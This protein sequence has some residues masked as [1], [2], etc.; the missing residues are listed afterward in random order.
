M[1]TI[2]PTLKIKD[3]HQQNGIYELRIGRL[4]LRKGETED[5][6]YMQFEDAF[7]K[8][9][10]I[11]RVRFLTSK[12]NFSDGEMNIPKP[13][14]TNSKGE[15]TESGDDVLY[16]YLNGT[17]EQIV[18]MGSLGNMQTEHNDMLIGGNY[19][20]N[21][22]T[23]TK[24]LKNKTRYL[25]QTITE[26]GDIFLDL[27]GFE[28][29]TGNIVIK[30]RGGDKGGFV[31]VETDGRI[32]LNQVDK[33]NKLQAQLIFDNDTAGE[34]NITL[35][36]KNDNNIEMNKEG[37]ILEGKMIRASN[38]DKSI[39]LEKI[40]TEIINQILA[41]QFTT[42]TGSTIPNPLNSAQ[43]KLIQTEMIDKLFIV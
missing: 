13:F 26:D 12:W 15:V 27:E 11:N 40:L 25:F 28:E 9:N 43:I 37:L 24:I 7:G 5:K 3:K 39:S 42:N 10:D 30:V 16:S 34:E 8:S 19:K 2:R 18:I 32:E 29:S 14:I 1:N 35:I 20:D 21:Y 23:Y 22:D 31:K 38:L 6:D 17:M 41:L 4:M 33:D 36:D